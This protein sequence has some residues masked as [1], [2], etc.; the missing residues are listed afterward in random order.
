MVPAARQGRWFCHKVLHKIYTII[1]LV[2][3][4]DPPPPSP[5]NS[6][7]RM[8][9]LPALWLC[10]AKPNQTMPCHAVPLGMVTHHAELRDVMQGHGVQVW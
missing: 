3:K 2:I 9:Q 5:P 6:G 7:S 4:T 8:E 1:Y 10:H